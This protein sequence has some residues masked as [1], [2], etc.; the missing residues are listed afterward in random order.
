M[1]LPDY[2]FL[3]APLWL[4][5]VLHIV[6]LTLHFVAMNFLL[7]GVIVVLFAKLK[8][9]WNDPTIRKFVKMFPNA[10]AAT[11]TI[12][13]APLLF[14]QLVF[15]RQTYAASIISGWFWLMIVIAV[16]IGYYFL[17]ASSFSKKSPGNKPVYLSLALICLL[18]VSFIYSSVFSMAERPEFFKS[19]YAGNQSGLLINP[20][21][22]SY[23]F[24]WLHMVLGAVTVGGFFVGIIGK[25][26]QPAFNL[27]KRVYLWGMVVTM[28]V[29]LVYMMTLGD[30]LRPFMRSAAIWLVLVSFILSLASLHFMFK[31]KFLISGT[32][33]FI[34]LVGMVVTR[35][36]LRLIYLEG[37]PQ[38]FEPTSLPV[39]PQW[40]IFIVFLVFFLIAVG[41]VW[42]MIKIFFS[43][44]NHTV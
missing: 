11:V 18:Y 1:N 6:T 43:E 2:N 34:S 22:N 41:L 24:R 20:D 25:D 31:K 8:D 14:V 35:Y 26:N 7:G 4:I 40:G 38:P 44:N 42:Y 19:L 5:T 30:H 23:I 39:E 16:I 21:L 29:G 3:S 28:I 36:I 27:G 10:M 15:H 32:A 37:G 12:G 33:L 17:Y 9:K 13:V